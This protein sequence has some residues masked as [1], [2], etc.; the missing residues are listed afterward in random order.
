MLIIVNSLLELEFAQD[1][2]GWVRGW[3]T[4]G[5]AVLTTDNLYEQSNLN[6]FMFKVCN[7]RCLL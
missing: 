6:V 5:S 3:T 7:G 4:A 1:D 2:N